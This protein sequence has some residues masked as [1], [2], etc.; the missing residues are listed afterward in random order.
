MVKIP[1]DY[2]LILCCLPTP[3]P[4][5]QHLSADVS[6]MNVFFRHSRKGAGLLLVT[7]AGLLIL[8]QTPGSGR[9]PLFFFNDCQATTGLRIS[10]I[11][12]VAS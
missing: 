5:H 4:A 11:I 12:F 2:W 1:D 7:E 3:V 10:P 8:D 9:K 6:L